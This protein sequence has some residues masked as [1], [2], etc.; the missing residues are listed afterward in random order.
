MDYYDDI[1]NVKNYIEIAKGCDASKLISKLKKYAAKNSRVLELG[2]GPGNDLKILNEYFKATGSDKYK[3]FLDEYK[4]NNKDADVLLLDALTIDTDRKF[5]V[6]YSNKVLMH[7][8]KEEL[9]KSIKNQLKCLDNDGIIF[10]TFWKGDGEES[11]GGMLNV[12]YKEDE[13][14]HI[15]SD[16]F[17]I[18]LLESY[19][20]FEEDDSIIVIAKKK[21]INKF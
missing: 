9:K 15:I 11:H 7:L 5:D 8:T 21:Y 17:T 19:A 20:E 14:N 6:V 10:H 12:Y 13:L 2:M 18:L 1:K 3:N 4:N 16:D